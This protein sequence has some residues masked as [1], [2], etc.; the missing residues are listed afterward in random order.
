MMATF[1]PSPAN[2]AASE[3]PACPVPMMIASYFVAIA[4]PPDNPQVSLRSPK[5]AR[6]MQE[7]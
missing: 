7:I 2:L 4:L 1:I 3:G 6:I 5:L